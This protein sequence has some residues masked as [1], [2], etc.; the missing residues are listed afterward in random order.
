[1]IF[2]LVSKYRCSSFSE[3][4]EKAGAT[5]KV[6]GFDARLLR[7]NL[8]PNTCGVGSHKAVGRFHAQV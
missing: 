6:Q 4:R 2:F 3:E 8:A 1:M 7:E 5:F